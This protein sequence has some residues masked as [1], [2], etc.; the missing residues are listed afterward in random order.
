[1]KTDIQPLKRSDYSEDVE[2]VLRKNGKDYCEKCGNLVHGSEVSPDRLERWLSGKEKVICP[3][4]RNIFS[5]KRRIVILMALLVA[6][7]AMI[8]MI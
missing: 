6:S 5:V 7:I 2:L 3:T 4:C 8:I 1:M